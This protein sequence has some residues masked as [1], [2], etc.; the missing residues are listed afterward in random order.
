M[1]FKSGRL[2][3]GSV[4]VSDRE[5]L[6]A[7]FRLKLKKVGKTTRPFIYDLNQ[8]PYKYTLKVKNRFER[9]ELVDRVPVEV[10]MEVHKIVQEPSQ[11]KKSK[12]E[13]KV[14]V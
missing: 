5:L 13:G 8:V 1:L 9:L 10:W 4:S 6:I 3:P 2:R 12:Q 7:K 14:V 11:R